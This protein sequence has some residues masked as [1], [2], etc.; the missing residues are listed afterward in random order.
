[1]DKSDSDCARLSGG[2]TPE[3]ER[4][5][6]LSSLSSSCRL[7][8]E[9]SNDYSPDRVLEEFP[10]NMLLEERALI[11]GRLKKHDKVLSIYINILGDVA[12]ATSYA[13]ANFKDDEKIFHTLVK[14]IMLPPTEPPYEGVTLHPDFVEVNREVLLDLLNT[15]ATKIDPFD[16]FEVILA[17][18]VYTFG[19]NSPFI[20]VPSR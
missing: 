17:W 8:L 15:Y 18:S 11:L 20:V 1:M 4:E 14:C 9:E 19:T 6:L 16:I 2:M 10:T 13:Q 7:V 3:S 12:K 5:C